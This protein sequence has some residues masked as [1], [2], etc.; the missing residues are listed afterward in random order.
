MCFS[1]FVCLFLPL[2]FRELSVPFLL[3]PSFLILF[4]DMLNPSLQSVD[5][6]LLVCID[7]IT[8]FVCIESLLVSLSLSRLLLSSPSPPGR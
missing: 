3:N 8:F 7:Q 4:S 6:G 1:F 2:L 5:L